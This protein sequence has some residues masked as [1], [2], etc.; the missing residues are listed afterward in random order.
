MQYF[1]QGTGFLA[2]ALI[3]ALAIYA[4]VIMGMFLIK[5]KKIIEK[6][7]FF[8][9]EFLFIVYIIM[10][11]DITG[12]IGTKWSFC[13]YGVQYNLTLFDQDT[14]AM[15]AMNVLMFIPLGIFLPWI[16]YRGKGN[17]LRTVLTG[18]MVSLSIEL[19][20][21]YFVGRL[22]DVDDLLFNTLGAAMGYMIYL[23]AAGIYCNVD[24]ICYSAIVLALA[25]IFCLLKY[26]DSYL[27]GEYYGQ[28]ISLGLAGVA[29]LIAVYAKAAKHKRYS[30]LWLA[31]AAVCLALVNI[32]IL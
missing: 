13:E 29:F 3:P 30:G 8:I 12:L 28:Y 1:M 17:F 16:F 20:Q 31:V 14:Q 21:M 18:F 9:R 2:K 11:A 25:S 10:V 23:L 7:K 5:K 15:M 4:I 6:R 27:F 19:I 26:G 22:G 24:N 32:F